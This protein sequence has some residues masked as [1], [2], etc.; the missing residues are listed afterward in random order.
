MSRRYAKRTFKRATSSGYS[1]ERTTFLSDLI[2]STAVQGTTVAI[3]VVPAS[4][5]QGKRTVGKFLVNPFIARQNTDEGF[6]YGYVLC[7]R[8]EGTTVL[9]PDWAVNNSPGTVN[10]LYEPNQDVLSFGVWTTQTNPSLRVRS[11]SYRKLHKG[12][13]VVL[14]LTKLDIVSS[15]VNVY[16]NGVVQYSIKYN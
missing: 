1:I 10:S 16:F 11:S 6:E 14:F 5:T 2:P 8:R 13:S 7:L 12:D 4:T 3:T 15:S 9:G